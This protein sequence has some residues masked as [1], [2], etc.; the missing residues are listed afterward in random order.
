MT[1]IRAVEVFDAAMCVGEQTL[2][3]L[4]M[5]KV[6]ALLESDG[7]FSF[8]F[9]PIID[10]VDRTVYSY[11]ALVRGPRSGPSAGFESL[12]IPPIIAGLF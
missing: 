8:A 7:G 3:S 4:V 10:V 5:G 6:M 2:A 9:Q 12:S 1:R 11:E